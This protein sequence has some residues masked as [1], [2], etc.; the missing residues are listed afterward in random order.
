MGKKKK[1]KTGLKGSVKDF[2]ADYNPIGTNDILDI[3][4][5]P[6]KKRQYKIIFGII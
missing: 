2:S 1:K 4:R 5:Y 3:H 6:M